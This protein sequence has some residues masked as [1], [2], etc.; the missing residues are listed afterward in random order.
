MIEA[1][2]RY[3]EI[4]KD[5]LN[6]VS[7]KMA[8]EYHLAGK[9]TVAPSARPF[10]NNIQ[11]LRLIAAYAI[12]YVHLELVF[13]AIDAGSAVV[14]MLRFGTDLFLVVSGFLSAHVLG[15][16]GKPAFVYLRDRAIRIL[17]LYFVFTILAFLTK[18]YTQGY[19]APTFQELLMSLA[20]IPYGTYPIL[21][22]TWTLI[23]IVE[24]SV[25]VAACQ[26]ISVRNGVY[27]S[28]IVIVLIAMIGVFV[29]PD[30]PML[31][32]YTNPII[33]DFALGVIIYK[34]TSIASF[35]YLPT[36]S[37]MLASVAIIGVCAVAVILR[38]FFWPA[39][40]RLVGL[41][42]PASGLLLG[43]V[44]LEKVGL[45]VNSAPANF[46]AKCAYSIYLCHEFV[47]GASEK[48]ISNSHASFL[49]PILIL[50]ITPFIVTAI[51]IL[52]FIYVEAPVTR[53]LSGRIS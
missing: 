52:T 47:N 30:M 49:G 1:K 31:V 28:S 37:A 16:S 32:S 42:L 11:I 43:A 21:H 34:I 27:I 12:V 18:N 24:F 38:P 10:C 20:F 8:T 2:S 9:R 26:K 23:L 6:P 19:G 4:A 25:I 33:V 17:P 53:Y 46:L 3:F 45:S 48:M 51:S 50:I 22:P 7:V 36:K 44:A 41:G 29:P 35:S 5:I 15:K 14:D 39:V 40:P 13:D